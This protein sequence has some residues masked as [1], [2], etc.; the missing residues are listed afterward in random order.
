MILADGVRFPS[1]ADTSN[2]RRFNDTGSNEVN[3]A[4]HLRD[5]VAVNLLVIAASDL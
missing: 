3:Y 1:S 5:I 4:V 2:G